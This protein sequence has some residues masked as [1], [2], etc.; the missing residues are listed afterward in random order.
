[1]RNSYKTI[2]NTVALATALTFSAAAFAPFAAAGGERGGRGGPD[3]INNGGDGGA[4]GRGGQ[5]GPGGEGGAANAN[6]TGNAQ[7]VNVRS[8][9]LGLP[10]TGFFAPASGCQDGWGISLGGFGSPGGGG[11]GF[12]RLKPAGVDMGAYTISEYKQLPHEK[13]E[14]IADKLWSSDRATLNCLLHQEQQFENRLAGERAMNTASGAAN[15]EAE[16][17]RMRGAVEVARI[18]AMTKMAMP[19]R[20]HDCNGSMV[21]V[22]KGAH[23]DPQS[24]SV[25]SPE[26][27]KKLKKNNGDAGHEKCEQDT[28]RLVDAVLD[29]KA[30]EGFLNPKELE[31]V[32]TQDHPVLEPAH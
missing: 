23:V 3:V 28:K 27:I 11:F 1:M 10:S 29:R 31:T 13:R 30:S 17:V 26:D 4:G 7:S 25:R 15:V 9:F 12:Q 22:P 5:G 2:F 32:A 6:N 16:K 20:A 18:E 24:R 19:G 21:V 14:E 8:S